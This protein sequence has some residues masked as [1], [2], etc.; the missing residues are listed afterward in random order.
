M[1]GIVIHFRQSDTLAICGAPLG[2][3]DIHPADANE[4]T[5]RIVTCHSCREIA[6]A[7]RGIKCS[8]GDF[9]LKREPSSCSAGLK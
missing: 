6:T 7:S 5:E 8:A 4:E 3:E 9:M 1:I 2:T